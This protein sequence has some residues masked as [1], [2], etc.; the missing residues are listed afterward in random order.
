MLRYTAVVLAQSSCWWMWCWAAPQ[1]METPY[2]S[3]TEALHP[4]ESLIGAHAWHL[5]CYIQDIPATYCPKMTSKQKR[6]AIASGQVACFL[7]S[8]L[9]LWSLL[10]LENFL[11][12]SKQYSNNCE[13]F[14]HF[15]K[16]QGRKLKDTSAFFT[17]GRGSNQPELPFS[18]IFNDFQNQEAIQSFKLE[19]RRTTIRNNQVCREE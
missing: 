3:K 6:D 14:A 11:E 7:I 4:S 9:I 13:L 16:K 19:V 15:P 2:L 5:W 10:N 17:E 8:L 12:I 18:C 1:L